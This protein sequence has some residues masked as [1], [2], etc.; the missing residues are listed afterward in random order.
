MDLASALE[1]ARADRKDG[2]S[3]GVGLLL[4]ALEGKDKKA[5]V[6]YLEN[7]DVRHTEIAAAIK[8]AGLNP[9][10]ATD[11]VSRHRRQVCS[12]TRSN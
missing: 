12:C 8:A 2:P 1:K 4:A 10:P 3:C 6:A 5:L 11:A 7:P 9:Q